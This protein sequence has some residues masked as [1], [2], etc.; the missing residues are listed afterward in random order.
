MARYCTRM[1]GQ[2]A[3][4][5]PNPWLRAMLPAGGKTSQHVMTH[6]RTRAVVS[7]SVV[8]VLS[9]DM[10]AAVNVVTLPP[11]LQRCTRSSAHGIRPA[12]SKN[13]VQSNTAK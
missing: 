9:S 10:L 12:V 13:F 8:I 2:P 6:G 7:C 5:Q 1:G 4:Q 3:M 11:W